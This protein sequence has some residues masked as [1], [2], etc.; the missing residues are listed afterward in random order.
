[1][2]MKKVVTHETPVGVSVTQAH[3]TWNE[4]VQVKKVKIIQHI[5]ETCVEKN[6][7][8]KKKV[9]ISRWASNEELLSQ[10][11]EHSVSNVSLSFQLYLGHLNLRN[12]KVKKLFSTT[13]V[14]WKQQAPTFHSFGTGN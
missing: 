11:G 3:T 13:P 8:R 5:C 2:S 1:M 7:S 14:Q 6:V 4:S 9:F 10:C 12:N